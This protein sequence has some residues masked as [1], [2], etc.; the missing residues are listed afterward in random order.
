[1]R[2]EDEGHEESKTTAPGILVLTSLGSMGKQPHWWP[3]ARTGQ[4]LSQASLKALFHSSMEK[5]A[6]F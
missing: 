4:S 2:E 6:W 3:P 5:L 1:M